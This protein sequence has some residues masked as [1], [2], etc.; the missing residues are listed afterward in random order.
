M[1]EASYTE[2]GNSVCV[3]RLNEERGRSSE[4]S[5]RDVVYRLFWLFVFPVCYLTAEHALFRSGPHNTELVRT[6]HKKILTH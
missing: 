6:A 1:R 4:H 2:I 3:A 5:Y